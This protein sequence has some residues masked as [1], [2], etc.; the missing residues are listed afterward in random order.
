MLMFKARNDEFLGLK[1][2]KPLFYS[3]ELQNPM[4]YRISGQ[5]LDFTYPQ[6]VF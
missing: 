2:I 1:G 6:Q 4:Y 5:R 3:Q